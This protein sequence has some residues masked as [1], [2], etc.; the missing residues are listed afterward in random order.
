MDEKE[1]IINFFPLFLFFPDNLNLNK[2][3]LYTILPSSLDQVPWRFGRDT[4][5]RIFILYRLLPVLPGSHLQASG[6]GVSVPEDLILVIR[7]C[8]EGKISF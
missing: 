8:S 6:S 3:R 2:K 1:S 7:N 4:L 5:V